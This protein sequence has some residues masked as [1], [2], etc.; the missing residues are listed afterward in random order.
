MDHGKIWKRVVS[1]TIRPCLL[2]KHNKLPIPNYALSNGDLERYASC[3]K[4]PFFRGVFMRDR[5]PSKIWE[6][7]TGIVNLDDYSGKGTHWVCYKKLQHNIYYFDSIGNIPPPIELLQYFKPATHVMYNNDNKQPI[8]TSIC[9]HLCL[10][11]L[12][13]PVSAL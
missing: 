1:K 8:N 3:L 12:A 9:G 7:E 6:N 11:F 4:I 5:L 13:T 10:E 2:N